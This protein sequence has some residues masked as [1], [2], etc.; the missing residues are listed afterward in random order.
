VNQVTQV[1]GIAA[2]VTLV[3][4]LGGCASKPEMTQAGFLSD[5]SR[6][7]AQ[8]KSR[9]VYQSAAT[10]QYDQWIVDP[11][12]VR[13]GPGKLSAKERAEV[14][15][16]LTDTLER[17]FEELGFKL[18]DTPG[19]GVARFRLA[20]TDVA[21]ST[22]WQKLHPATRAIGAGTGGAAMEAEAIDSVSGEQIGAIIQAETGNQFDVLAFSTVDDVK[23]AIDK[24]AELFKKNVREF[25]SQ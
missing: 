20:I 16:Y 24:W 11:V 25:R 13:G 2:I 9:M 19:V 6:L 18:T 23:N 1:R 15:R 5:Y 4:C 10:W 7:S 3:A 22:W 12:Q 14:A 17:S 8:S 21:Q